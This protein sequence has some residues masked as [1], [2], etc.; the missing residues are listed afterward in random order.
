MQMD[1]KQAYEH[2]LWMLFFLLRKHSFSILY[3][4]YSYL[5]FQTSINFYL[6]QEDSFLQEA[7]FFL[8]RVKKRRQEYTKELYKKDLHDPDIHDGVITHL[9]Q[10]IL[11]CEVKWALKA[12]LWTKLVEVMKFQQSY[13]KSWKMMLWK[14]C[15]QYASKFGKLSSGHRI[16]KVQVSFQFQRKAMSKSAQTT[17]QLYS[18]LTLVK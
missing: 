16:G 14:C 15:T 17:T 8:C 2:D 6:I 10:D 13:F 7:F 4:A 3:W 11:E 5:W 12:S 9:E 1:I 18:S